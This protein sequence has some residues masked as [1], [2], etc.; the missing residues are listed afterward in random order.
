MLKSVRFPKFIAQALGAIAL[1]LSTVDANAI[2]LR[3]KFKVD[4]SGPRMYACNAGIMA[5]TTNNRVCYFAGTTNTCTPTSCSDADKVCHSS[6]V[7]SSTNGGDY[8]MNYGKLNWVGQ[9]PGTGSGNRTFRGTSGTQYEQ[10]FTDSDAWGKRI[11]DLSFHLGSE[12]YSAKYFVDICYNGPQIEYYEDNIATNFV[13]S[14][15]QA[16]AI[17]ALYTGKV[18]GENSREGM[19]IGQG[20]YLKNANVKVEAFMTCDLQGVGTYVYARNNQDKYNT[21]D[22]EASFVFGSNQTPINASEGAASFFSGSAPTSLTG[23]TIDLMKDRTITSNSGKTPRHCKIRYVFT[24]TNWN[25]SAPKL[26][27]WEKEGA[28][29]CTYTEIAEPPVQQ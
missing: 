13:L 2:S 25:S 24:E 21:L 22:N 8:L 3:Y 1:I 17:D 16:Y 7:C 29:M 12:L 15:A 9:S 10:A 18:P 4:S 11:T 27:A 20:N 26:R 14:Y 19:L 23:T 6:C 5:Q 28:E